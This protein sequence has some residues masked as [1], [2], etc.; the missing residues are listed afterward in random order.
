[1]NLSA[2]ATATVL[3][4]A[5]T[6]LVHHV[7]WIAVCWGASVMTIAG[8]FRLLSEWQRR[9]TLV[10]ILQH[11]REGTV[12]V[13]ERGLGGPAMW[14]RVGSGPSPDSGPASIAKPGTR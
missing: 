1:M 10:A 14:V 6:A 7:S 12:I 4:R 5:S 11:A 9:M 13:Q 8:L 3:G 2:S